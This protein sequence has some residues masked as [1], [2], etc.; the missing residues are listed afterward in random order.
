MGRKRN[1]KRPRRRG[2]GWP[3]TVKRTTAA[4]T[5][6]VRMRRPPARGE[7]R[8]A[9][10]VTTDNPHWR[11]GAAISVALAI[12]AAVAASQTSGVVR[13]GCMLAGILVALPAVS[14]AGIAI[15][16][17]LLTTLDGPPASE[18]ERRRAGERDSRHSQRNRARLVAVALALILG[19]AGATWY[20]LSPG[21]GSYQ[22]SVL[23]M[24][25]T[26]AIAL[27]CL[28]HRMSRRVQWAL[29][30]A[31]APIG[32]IGYVFVGGTQ[33]WNWGQLTVLPLVLLVTGAARSTNS[34]QP[35][36]YGGFRDGPWGPP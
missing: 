4:R 3:E 20:A 26:V 6:D 13:T 5:D 10:G 14:T 21:I 34:D 28:H 36:A 24:L 19:A 12:V 22:L 18:V 32:P 29:G 9:G 35:A 25:P 17:L 15:L 16:G 2:P 23:M 30:L 1:S 33:W 31:L 27:I 8:I 7:Y 11:R